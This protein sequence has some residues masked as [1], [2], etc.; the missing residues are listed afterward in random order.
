VAE[1]NKANSGQTQDPRY[2]IKGR[3]SEVYALGT[4]S[5]VQKTEY[6]SFSFTDMHLSVNMRFLGKK[7]PVEP[8]LIQEKI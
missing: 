8:G 6:H 2:K 5:N 7:Q 3:K 1:K 4:I